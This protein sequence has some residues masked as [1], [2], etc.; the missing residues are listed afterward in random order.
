MGRQQW[1][2]VGCYITP[3]DASTIE[4]VAV[5]ISRRTQKADL[6]VA[7]DFNANMDEPEGT[8]CAE[9]NS[10]ALGAS[11][12]EDM[13]AHSILRRKPWS[14]DGCTWL[15][16]R[17]DQVMRSQTDN[18]LGMDHH[19]YQSVSVWYALHNTDH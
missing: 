7:G 17:R 10:T 18:L 9:Y 19:L 12:L 16:L 11:G 1:H 14:M 2:V 5:A 15:I 13:S 8:M 3:D 6:L 4:D